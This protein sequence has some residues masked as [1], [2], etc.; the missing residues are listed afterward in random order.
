M[1]NKIA[2]PGLGIGIMNIKSTVTI[3]GFDIHWYGII[4]A[5]GI[6]LAY[7]FASH[8]GKKRDISQDT[9]LDVIIYGLPSAIICARLYYVIFSWDSYKNNL[10]DIFKIWEGGL[11][12][13]GGVI[14][15]VL[16]TA[17]YC[18]VK[19]ISFLKIADLGGFGLLIGQAVGR[20]GNFVNAEAYGAETT[21]PWRMELVDLGVFVHP[22]F[23]YESL[24]NITVFSVL[25]WYRK[26]QKADGEIFFAYLAGYG[27]GR[28]WIEGLRLDSLM[29]G[30]V[31]ISQ[32]L[33][34]V[35]VLAGVGMVVYLR[36]RKNTLNIA[37]SNS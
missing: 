2:F 5:L 9:V 13:Y 33:A 15:A 10:S 28:L 19:K 12:I 14:G 34:G 36:K 17:I 32:I 16:S 31:R 35:C 21:L 18:K 4:I 29:L 6:V 7:L 37:D 8:E 24:W 22:T 25:L 26:K 30:P 3:F 11:A 1:I 20:W 27:L 23:L